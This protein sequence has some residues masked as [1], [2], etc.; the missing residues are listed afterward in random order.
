MEDNMC[1]NTNEVDFWNCEFDTKVTGWC[2]VTLLKDGK[3][4][5]FEELSDND[6]SRAFKYLIQALEREID[7]GKEAS[8]G[9]DL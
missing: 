5:V 9:E 6:K 2:D 7:Y 8:Y 4:V 1:T 3:P